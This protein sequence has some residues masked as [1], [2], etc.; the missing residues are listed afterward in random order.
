MSN[1]NIAAAGLPV[2]NASS[3][4]VGSKQSSTEAES[5][6][7]GREFES[8]FEKSS[9]GSGQ[10]S[11]EDGESRYSLARVFSTDGGTSVASRVAISQNKA[12]AS[13]TSTDQPEP[14]KD[15]TKAAATDTLGEAQSH[16]LENGEAVGDD[17]ATVGKEGKR[18]A[19]RVRHAA[20]DETGDDGTDEDGDDLLALLDAASQVAKDNG[21]ATAQQP[22]GRTDA[23]P[24]TAGD[25]DA[26]TMQALQAAV[27]A[28]D[29]MIGQ[30]ANG[31]TVKQVAGE[32]AESKS[33]ARLGGTSSSSDQALP[34]TDGNAAS[35]EV[36][37]S[38]ADQIFKFVRADGKG[39]EIEL[40]IGGRGDVAT[41]KDAP[42]SVADDTVTVLDSRRYLGLAS[43]TNSAAV[44]AAIAQ[45]AEWAS[46]LT[47]GAATM[48]D[49]AVTGKA[50]HTLKI[51]M[52]P[53]DLGSVTA[54]LRLS[55]DELVV[56]LQVE[57][58]EAYRQLSGDQDG[59]VKALKAQG[60]AV[61]QVTV[62]FS[63]TDRSSANS[64]GNGQAAFAG[65]QQTHEGNGGR[66][67]GN[68]QTFSGQNSA[69]NDGASYD[70]SLAESAVSSGVQSGRGG[71]Y[72]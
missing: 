35:G 2:G 52:Q 8:V 10:Q 6:S 31:R 68:Q 57:T 72:L 33:V 17:P 65:Q 20:G 40:A 15:H 24:Q 54:T 19:D 12:G 61:D 58:G 27:G 51:Q 38:A 53:I 44:T 26:E 16:L 23:A 36:G 64:Q 59:I 7:R 11:K 1:L 28:Q 47:S 34:A 71:V 69:G 21:T 5:V 37:P 60:F 42:L 25:T 49:D 62:Q 45:D 56:N 39:K 70:R 3:A 66:Q 30:Q 29:P 55:G 67:G 63:P 13:D 9:G 22:A 41:V 43:T 18:A 46:Q 32:K 14:A 50:V 48:A 4:K